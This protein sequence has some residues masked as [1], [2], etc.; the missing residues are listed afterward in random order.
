MK[1]MQSNPDPK[2]LSSHK[3]GKG[4]TVDLSISL[5]LRNIHTALQLFDFLENY[6][7]CKI[8]YCTYMCFTPL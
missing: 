5:K 7:T 2:F 4:P 8:M 1:L 6:S 3:C